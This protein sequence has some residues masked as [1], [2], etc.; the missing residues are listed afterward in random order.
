MALAKRTI[1]Y[2]GAMLDQKEIEA[3]VGVM[4]AEYGMVVGQKVGEFEKRCA[5]LLGHTHGVMVNSGS[6][7]LML[8]MRML[9]VLGVPK[10]SEVI[11][12]VLTFST[13]AAS[14]VHAGFV[15]AF[16]DVGLSD[17]Q[18]DLDKVEDM[19]TPKTKAILVPNLVGGVPD[20]D[21][22]RAIAD[23]HGLILVE[24]SCDTLGATLRGT[25]TGK[26]ADITVTSF[27][28]FHI[29]TCL[30]NGGLVA[31]DDEKLWD[32]GLMARAWG[33]SSEKYLHGTKVKDSDGRFLEDLDGVPYD[34][35]FIFEDIA[36]GFIPNE[37]GAA[38]GLEQLNKLETFFT[39]R[40]SRFQ[41]HA[42]FLKKHRDV[43]ISADLIDDVKTSWICYPVQLRPELGW[44]RR[45]LQVDLEDAGVFTRVIFSGNITRH[46]MMKGVEYRRAPGG[47]PVADQIMEQGLMLPCHP[48]MTDEDCEYLYQVLEEW[49]EKQRRR[50]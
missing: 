2:G 4:Q 3:V 32:W 31:V 40:D 15:P 17:Y 24:D 48:T 9:G 50:N 41:K 23:K 16:V 34:G 26:R 33:R 12:P 37:A 1:R 8:A 22:L 5:A 49:I 29:I 7:A 30:G 14:I 42:E 13:D 28:I 43:F 45:A 44:S 36:Y 6:S 38:F 47:Y 21:R 20:W 39:L 35:M 46:P 27:S 18:I 11:T 19:I 10:G 25:P